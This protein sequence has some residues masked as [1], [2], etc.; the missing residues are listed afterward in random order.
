MAW[1]WY[2]LAL[3][4]LVAMYFSPTLL[5]GLACMLAS[6]LLTLLA[7]MTRLAAVHATTTSARR[8]P[9]ERQIR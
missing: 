3:A 4:S 1:F 7:T 2:A 5:L 6:L 9:G 8:A